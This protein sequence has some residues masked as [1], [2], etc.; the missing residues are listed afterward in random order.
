LPPRNIPNSFTLH[1]YIHL[2]ISYGIEMYANTTADRLS[3]LKVMIM[4]II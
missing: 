3:I 2:H 1:L 4:A